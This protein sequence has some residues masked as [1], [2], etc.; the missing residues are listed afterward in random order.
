VSEYIEYLKEMF[1][2]LGPVT[3]RKM[4]GGYGVYYD[5]V[6]FGLVAD[7]TLYLKVDETTIDDFTSRGLTPF[8]YNKAGK[9]MKMSYYLA[10]DEVL[11][12][13]DDATHWGRR[14]CDVALRAKRK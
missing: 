13:P 9:I 14:A 3:A 11:E 5:G 6:M 2:G 1:Q 12:N 8:E 4:F 10:P 7:D